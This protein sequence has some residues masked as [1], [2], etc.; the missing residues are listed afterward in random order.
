MA[1][2]LNAVSIL[3]WAGAFL[4]ALVHPPHS[5]ALPGLFFT[6]PLAAMAAILGCAVLTRRSDWNSTG[7]MLLLAASVIATPWYFIVFTSA[8][9][10]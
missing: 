1:L 4:F 3:L 9:E 2:I 7:A 8:I 10:S 5:P 6:I